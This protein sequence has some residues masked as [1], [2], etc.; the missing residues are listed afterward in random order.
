MDFID[1]SKRL[2]E[3]YKNVYEAEADIRC[4]VCQ[5]KLEN[6]PAIIF[7]DK[8]SKDIK[9]CNDCMLCDNCE[10]LVELEQDTEI[11]E[12][13]WVTVSKP[14]FAAGWASMPSEILKQCFIDTEV[15]LCS[16]CRVDY[17]RKCKHVCKNLCEECEETC[18]RCECDKIDA[19][20]ANSKLEY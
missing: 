4:A 13:N 7:K 15:L 19:N 10:G 17:C 14:C 18:D 1:S 8:E 11:D 2:H 9:I 6:P 3:Y 16:C 12:S 5:N 20:G